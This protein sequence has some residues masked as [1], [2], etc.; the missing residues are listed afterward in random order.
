VLQVDSATEWRGG[1][2]QLALLME[3]LEARGHQVW[4]AACPEGALAARLGRPVLAIPA[5]AGLRGAAVLRRH[6][7][8]LQPDIVA[9]QTSH[10]HALCALAG[11]RPVVHRRVDF[12]VGGSPWGRLKY[13]RASLYVAVSHG[14]AHV[15]EAG[16]V[17]PARIRVVHDGVRP[18]G[19]ARPAADLLGD[20]PLIGAVGALVGHKA[21]RVLVDAMA[22]L[23]DLRCVIAGEGPLRG[24]LERQICALGLQDR[25][26]LL[27]QR[28]DVAAVLAALDLL[29]HPSVEEGMGQVV[30]EAMAARVPVLVSDAGGLP[31][32]VGPRARVAPRGDPR[33]LAAMIRQ[34]LA[35][36]DPVS[37]AANRARERFSVAGMVEGTLSAYHEAVEH[38]R[39]PDRRTA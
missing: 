26:R 38:R 39:R 33:A 5:G 6:V 32:V 28:G 13:G 7:R 1:Q 31:E 18:L 21:H 8:R 37:Q 29:V 23:P 27:G 10:A 36:P 19:P 9:A 15:L 12:A 16:G 22:R 35:Q 25:V 2:V 3:G 17:A 20:G 30:V 24:E 14:V 4:L 11:L 34:H